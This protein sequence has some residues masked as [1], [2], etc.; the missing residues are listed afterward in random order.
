MN[1]VIFLVILGGALG[2]VIALAAK[3]FAVKTDPRVEEV[4]ELLPQ[5]NCGACGY[6]GCAEFARALVEGEATPENCP[7]SSPD[8][9]QQIASVLGVSLGERLEKVAVVRCGGDNRLANWNANYNGILDCRSANLVAGGTK[10]CQYGCLG[11]GTCAR[12]CP[13][14][15]IEITPHGL[16]VVHPDV[17]TGCGKC[18][19]A[20]PRNLIEL[21]PKDAPL[22]NLCNNPEKGAQSRK[23]CDV[24]CIACQKCVKS[25]EEGQMYMDGFIARVNYENPPSADLAEVCPTK[26]LQ[27]S[28]L[29]KQSMPALEHREEAQQEEEV[30]N[31]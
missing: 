10:A 15:A 19:A 12:A 27:P 26:C 25:A 7:V 6:A 22:H 13:F 31:A 9:V 3:A 4:E 21:V 20:C 8:E 14:D 18:V 23:V 2:F 28:L 16:A 17:C 1:A 11:L 5:A 29:V 30:A 24:S